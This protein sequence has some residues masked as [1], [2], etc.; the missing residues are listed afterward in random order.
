MNPRLM[1]RYLSRNSRFQVKRVLPPIHQTVLTVTV[2]VHHPSLPHSSIHQSAT[3]TS[4]LSSSYPLRYRSYFSATTFSTCYHVAISVP[5]HPRCFPHSP[6]SS[7]TPRTTASKTAST[8]TNLAKTQA[9][10]L[11]PQAAGDQ[12]ACNQLSSVNYLCIRSRTRQCT[13]IKSSAVV[14]AES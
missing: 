13:T 1:Y 6:L 8:N 5:H 2:G 10:V 3:T 14:R 9:T 12:R 7:D 4:P 11:N